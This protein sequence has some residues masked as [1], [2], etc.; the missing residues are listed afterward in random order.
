MTATTLPR[1]QAGPVQRKFL[2]GGF[3]LLAAVAFLI[4]NGLQTA[5][6]Y[7]LTVSEARTQLSA[8]SDQ[9]VRINGVA[10]LSTVNWDAQALRLSFDLV[11]GS[12]RLPVVYHGVMPDTFR[13]SE[14]VVVEGSLTRGG[15]FEAR[16]LLVKCPSR[17]EPVIAPSS[18]S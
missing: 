18:S 17:Y 15:L 8:G 16:T 4:A 11:E 13:Q 9:V 7:Y 12:N 6:V 2:V 1:S 5:S 3:A 10:D 14:S